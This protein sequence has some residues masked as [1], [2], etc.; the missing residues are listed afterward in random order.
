M[1]LFGMFA[2]FFLFLSG[3]HGV[4]RLQVLHLLH[5][6]IGEITDAFGVVHLFQ[7]DLIVILFA[8]L[9]DTLFQF[10]DQSVLEETMKNAEGVSDEG[11]YLFFEIA[12]GDENFLG[13]GRFL[14]FL[15]NADLL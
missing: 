1:D 4:L 6:F 5:E 15:G 13:I 2:R 12:L 9:G 7:L 14:F 3:D 8:K 10:P 11:R